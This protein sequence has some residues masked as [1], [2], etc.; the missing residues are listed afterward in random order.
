MN[1]VR[2]C[3]LWVA[4]LAGIAVMIPIALSYARIEP[5]QPP[6]PLEMAV[7]R[8]PIGVTA[9]EADKI[10]GSPPDKIGRGQ[11]IVANPSTMFSASSVQGQKYGKP[12]NFTFRTWNQDGVQ[13]SVAIDEAGRVA[14][15]WTYR[16]Q[17]EH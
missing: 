5:A 11:G 1:V 8:I 12:T 4:I 2:R 7:A 17:P 6:A 16:E 13:A 9:V 15:R 3:L 10:I 14:A